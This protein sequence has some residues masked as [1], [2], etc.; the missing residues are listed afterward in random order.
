M[1]TNKIKV[2]GSHVKVDNI[3]KVA[4]IELAEKER[5]KDKHCPTRCTCS[6]LTT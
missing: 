1:E 6:A 4:E 2:L 5:M 3:G